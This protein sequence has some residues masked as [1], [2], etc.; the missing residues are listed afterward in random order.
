ML[1]PHSPVWEADLNPYLGSPKPGGPRRLVPS[2]DGRAVAFTTGLWVPH[3]VL[4]GGGAG[5]EPLVGRGYGHARPVTAVAWH[6]SLNVLAS[7]SSDKTVNI[8]HLVEW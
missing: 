7:G 5:T 6:P 1:R 3:V 2:H 8:S 4:L